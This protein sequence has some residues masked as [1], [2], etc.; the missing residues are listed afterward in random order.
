MRVLLDAMGEPDPVLE[1]KILDG[2]VD[3]RELLE[4]VAKGN[5]EAFHAFYHCHGARVMAMIRRHVA[6]P[7]LAEELVQDVF[8][9]AWFGARG[10][11]D[12]MGDPE[13][14]LLG[15]A[16]HKVQD[17]WRRVQA[18]VRTMHAHVEQTQHATRIADVDLRLAIEEALAGLP[19]E[20]RRVLDLIYQGGLTFAETARALRVPQGTVKSRVHAALLTLRATFGR[21]A[22]S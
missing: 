5:R 8:V 2:A 14:W 22:R 3:S 21:Q 18:L 16:R 6:A 20:Q 12:E 7:Q 1:P 13:R 10:Y 9:A 19:V 4:R 17:H 11:R 15:I